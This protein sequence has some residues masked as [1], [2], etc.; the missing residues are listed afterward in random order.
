[1]PPTQHRMRT[2]RLP[3]LIQAPAIQKRQPLTLM[4]L[5]WLPTRATR[6]IPMSRWPPL[7]SLHQ[8]TV[9]R[10]EKLVQKSDPTLK[11]PMELQQSQTQT[12]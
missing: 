5:P 2:T 9:P 12:Q 4:A 1:M 8:G 6:R 11:V 10:S 3:M 7:T